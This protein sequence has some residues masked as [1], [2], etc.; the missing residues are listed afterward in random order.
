MMTSA[1]NALARTVRE[2][3]GLSKARTETA[4]WLVALFVKFGMCSLWRLAG[5]APSGA[6]TDSTR[7]RF[8]RFFQ[9][10]KISPWTYSRMIAALLGLDGK[11]W[12]L[13]IDRTNWEFG[14]TSI[15]ILMVSVTWRGIG[16]PLIWTLLPTRG[17]S[18]AQERIDLLDELF[19]TFPKMRIAALTGDRE[20]MGNRW[21]A[22]L[23][24][25]KVNYVMRIKENQYVARDGY[26]TM[27]VSDIARNLAR[28]ETMTLR[29]VCYLS[30]SDTPLRIVIM[31]LATGELL[32]VAARSRPRQAL[33]R[34][35][36]RWKIE[37]LFAALKT[38]GFNLEATHL[39]SP[40]KLST[41]IGLLA[42]ATAM[43]AKAGVAANRVRPVP[44][45]R[46][47][48]RAT[49]LF[50]YGLDLLRRAFAALAR[51]TRNTDHALDQLLIAILSPSMP[52]KPL[53]S[54]ALGR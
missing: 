26:M 51:L 19:A 54:A 3:T 44:V 9:H 47:G 46:H 5:H 30:G 13:A 37:A 45:K 6:Q 43:V 28:R 15:N 22:W 32:A 20:F 7:R 11:P 33:A 49:S 8:Y 17:N 52:R 48:R 40:A 12:E 42:V 41:L 23:H 34:Y 16:I 39:S 4:T 38:R 31:R 25:H 21:L 24:R 29:G 50:A 27:T 10:V 36:R 2:H 53:I 1:L 35:A 18:S 14:K